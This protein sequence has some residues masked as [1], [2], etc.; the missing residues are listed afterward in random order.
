MPTSA[1]P[2]SSWL[3][4]QA[5]VGIAGL[6]SIGYGSYLTFQSDI[7]DRVGALEVRVAVLE[8]KETDKDRRLD[9]LGNWIERQDKGEK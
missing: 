1:E 8:A 4:P 5:L 6:L 2:R 3:A 7:G 9:R